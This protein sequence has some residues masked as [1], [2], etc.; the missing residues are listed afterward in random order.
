[1]KRSVITIALVLGLVGIGIVIITVHFL[2]T[3]HMSEHYILH[4][5]QPS[6]QLIP[7][8]KWNCYYFTR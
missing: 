7:H 5:Q 8:M 1:M 6:M 2:I 3:P 4:C